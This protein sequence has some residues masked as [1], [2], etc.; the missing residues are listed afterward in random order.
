[1]NIRSQ[2][3]IGRIPAS[4]TALRQAALACLDVADR[5]RAREAEVKSDIGFT[6]VGRSKTLK[7]EASKSYLP[8]LD[9]AFRPIADALAAAKRARASISFTAPD[10][11]NITAA[12]ERQEIR[13]MV[14]GMKL[15]ER[16]A[17]LTGNKDERIADAVLSAPAPLSGLDDEQFGIVRD[18]A[19]DRR[20]GDK[21]AE[22]RAAEEAAEAAQA[23]MLVAGNEIKQITGVSDRQFDAMRKMGNDIPWLRNSFQ[24]GTRQPNGDF[25]GSL[26]GL[27]R[28]ETVY[29][30]T[31][32]ETSTREATADEIARGK[33]Y[34]S[35]NEYLSDHP[36]VRPVNI[37]AAA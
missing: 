33:F 3:L 20:F 28:R 7:D 17:F 2:Q 12:L 24:S 37:H 34:A 1:M 18:M 13:A 4:S 19:V 8:A 36:G 22:I 9:A 14:K 6:P 35:Y 21:V 26:E 10:P 29:V 31:P 25:V 5:F 23:A 15:G 30:I 11:S 32:G 27:D 16:M